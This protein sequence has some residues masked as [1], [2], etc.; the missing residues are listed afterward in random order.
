MLYKKPSLCNTQTFKH[1]FSIHVFFSLALLVPIVPLWIATT[2]TKGSPVVSTCS[3]H[4]LGLLFSEIDLHCFLQN[5]FTHSAYTLSH[6]QMYKRKWY[7]SASIQSHTNTI[8]ISPKRQNIHYL[9]CRYILYEISAET[10]WPCN[11]H[12]IATHFVLIL[13]GCVLFRLLS[14]DRK[15]SRRNKKK[16]SIQ[17]TFTHNEMAKIAESIDY[18]FCVVLSLIP[19]MQRRIIYFFNFYLSNRM[20]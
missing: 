8:P 1:G 16:N 10:E 15:K 17:T 3:S 9:K 11:F 2:I 14:T 13:S 12:F 6:T 7:G 5:G 4:S 19:A 20:W 18:V